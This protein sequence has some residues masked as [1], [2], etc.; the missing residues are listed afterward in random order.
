MLGVVPGCRQKPCCQLITSHWT[1]V[2]DQQKEEMRSDVRH[3]IWV[4]KL[5]LLGLLGDVN[6]QSVPTRMGMA[7]FLFLPTR[8]SLAFPDATRRPLLFQY[9]EGRRAV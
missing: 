7:M 9:G 2:S 1:S 4:S 3:P 8:K 6:V 5:M